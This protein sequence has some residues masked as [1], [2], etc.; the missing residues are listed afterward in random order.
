MANEPDWARL[1]A[2]GL[3]DPSAANASERRELLVYFTEQGITEPQMVA[4]LEG[5]RLTSL[6][7]D[8]TLR[9]DRDRYLRDE[10]AAAAGIDPDLVD[11][12][13]RAAG[14][15]AV[16]GDT[17]YYSDGDVEI[18]RAFTM[19]AS[20]FG[21]AAVL[22]FTR[23]L[24][25]SL[26]SIAEAALAMAVATL[27]GPLELAGADERTLA[28]TTA[29][30]AAALNSVPSVMAGLFSHHVEAATRRSALSR[31]DGALRTVTLAVGFL[32]LVGFTA[33]SDGLNPDELAAAV[34][35]FETMASEAIVAHD[36]RV[37]KM[38]GD[39]VMYVA[40]DPVAAAEIAL[41]LR[42]AISG[43]AVLSGLRGGVAFGDLVAQDGDYY[44]REVNLAAR[45]VALAEPG[46]V[47]ATAAVA[48]GISES[49]SITSSA[50]GERELKGFE[51]PVP[52]FELQRTP[53]PE[54]LDG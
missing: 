9:P 43:H 16:A 40:T 49:A 17:R 11:R 50:R 20:L 1:E 12:I 34:A 10:A 45:I 52:L 23:V 7:G 6:V 18:L 22:R 28:R 51:H 32:D 54:L 3:Y 39:E 37:V 35:G 21:D 36:A 27:S 30:S 41:D 8:L 13:W 48:D 26:S 29:E 53:P 5:N 33:R 38:I 19:G 42:D 44:G 25:T 31:T 46:G 14:L 47:L 2:L 4:A 15:P 24:G